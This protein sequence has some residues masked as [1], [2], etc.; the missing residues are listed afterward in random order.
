MHVDNWSEMQM[1][2]VWYLMF[3]VDLFYLFICQREDRVKKEDLER[4]RSENG[5]DCTPARALATQQT[6][7][8]QGSKDIMEIPEGETDTM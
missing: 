8:P 5:Y 7:Q 2:H 1:C 4:R 3:H 6:E